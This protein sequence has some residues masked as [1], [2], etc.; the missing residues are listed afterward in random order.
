M[1][2][3]DELGNEHA[4]IGI[5]GGE[6]AI[7]KQTGHIVKLGWHDHGIVSQAMTVIVAGKDRRYSFNPV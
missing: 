5:V 2:T 3:F 4:A 7:H 6:F 1:V